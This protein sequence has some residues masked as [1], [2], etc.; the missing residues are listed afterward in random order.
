[1]PDQT[2]DN[3]VFIAGPT[4][5]GKSALAINLAREIGGEIV[6]ADAMQV[7]RELKI[8]SAR[9]SEE[10]QADV[11]HHLFGVLS[12]DEPCSAGCW[13]AM[14]A[15]VISDVLAREK[16]AI[17]VGGTGLYFRTL[18]QGLSPI[19]DVP[20]DVRAEARARRERLGADAFYAEVV[21]ADPPMARIAPGDTQRLLR[22]WE[23]HRATGK[24]LSSFQAAPGAPIVANPCARLVLAPD[25]ENLYARCDVRFDAMMAAGA[26]DEARALLAA[27]FDPQLP[28]MKALG[29][30]ELL[31]H[32]RGD[33]DLDAAIDLAKRN[34]RR[35]AKRQMTWFRN[36]TPDWLR[37]Q[38][39][40]EAR[41]VLNR[42]FFASGA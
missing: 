14:A 22:A 6:N 1:M 33:L 9:P 11:A 38:T 39:P 2:V 27:E 42:A 34:T 30:A 40:D 31:A 7:Y 4:A 26:L 10:E 25:R 21:A 20:P 41:S 18:E 8:L 17:I 29:A 32:L 35:F 16:C 13:A 15:P 3:V 23:V 36:Q 19:P 12:G 37:V 24:P 5:S 28:I